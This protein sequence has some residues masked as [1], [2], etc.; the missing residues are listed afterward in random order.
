MALSTLP[1][2][3]PHEIV[4]VGDRMFTDVVLAHPRMFWARIAARLGIAYAPT[5]PQRRTRTQELGRR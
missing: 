4:V 3:T 1:D 2:L 5:L